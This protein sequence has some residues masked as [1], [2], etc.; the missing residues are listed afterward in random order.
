MGYKVENLKFRISLFQNILQYLYTEG[1][2]GGLVGW[3]CNSQQ[4]NNFL[5]SPYKS[6]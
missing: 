3:I 5:L 2:V 1:S 4:F 6:K